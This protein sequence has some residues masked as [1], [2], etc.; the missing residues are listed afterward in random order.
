MKRFIIAGT[1]S[2][3]GKTTVTCAVLSALKKRGTDLA[4]FKCGPDYIDPMFLRR[5]L[6]TDVHNL[7][8][9]F[10]G[11]DTLLY[12]LDEYGGSR[13]LSVI[14]GVMGFYDGAEGS[15]HALSQLTDTPVI[16]VIGCKGMSDSIGAVMRGFL[17]YR[18]NNIAG[19]VFDCL[20]ERL[21]PLARKLC[22]ELGT[23]YFG[24]LPQNGAALE[25]RHLGLVMPGE[26][27]DINEKLDRLGELAEKY[28]DLDGL[29]G[30][31]DIPL[32]EY[33]AP[34]I[35]RFGSEPVIAVAY[36]SAFCFLY[37]EN[38]GL[39]EKMGCK[40]EYFSPLSDKHLPG[41]DGLLLCGG[42]PELYGAELS[43]NASMLADIRE[44]ICSGMPVMAECGGFMYLHEKMTD[45]SG[46]TY[47]MAGVIKGRTFPTERLRRFGYITV[48]AREDGLLCGKGGS[49]KAH[50]FHYWDSTD[51]GADFLA[52]KSDGRSWE[53][54]HTGGSIYA[55]FPH[56]Y[57]Y[58]DTGMAVRFVEKCCEYGGKNG[59]HT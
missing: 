25:S 40:A 15:A 30:L 37:H 21:E 31:P 11:R 45:K 35:P 12:L 43:A 24:F 19:F 59:A 17:S 51:C 28:I 27:A 47:P 14:E 54:G 3:C 53:C 33:R 49:L 7:D 34:R 50:E 26:I 41:A 44:R 39:L 9:F 32:P 55:G 6:G 20:P 8:S 1:G 18:P 22:A 5:T 48:T 16:M 57:F 38:I 46:K 29:L 13:E 10:C 56:F 23:G 52:E 4:A 36:D 58:S 2:G 42:Y